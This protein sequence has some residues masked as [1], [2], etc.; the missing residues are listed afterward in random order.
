M[1]FS[2]SSQKRELVNPASM[3]QAL[4][5]SAR[6]LSVNMFEQGHA[7]NWISSEPIRSSTATSPRLGGVPRLSHC[8]LGSLSTGPYLPQNRTHPHQQGLGALGSFMLLLLLGYQDHS[9]LPILLFVILSDLK[10]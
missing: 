9:P 7:A 1:W 4:I 6:R 8:F 2:P 5:A 3:K 10:Q